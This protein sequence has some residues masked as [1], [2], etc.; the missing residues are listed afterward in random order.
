MTRTDVSSS[1]FLF[2]RLSLRSFLFLLFFPLIKFDVKLLSAANMPFLGFLSPSLRFSS[3]SEL[4]L[5]L[6]SELLLV[7]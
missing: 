3:S 6:S 1:A 4:E 5:S 2:L 7:I